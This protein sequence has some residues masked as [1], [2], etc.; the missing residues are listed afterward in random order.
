ME[1][2]QLQ[3]AMGWTSLIDDLDLGIRCFRKFYL[4]PTELKKTSAHF[5]TNDEIHDV[6][7]IDGA[8]C[9]TARLRKCKHRMPRAHRGCRGQVASREVHLLR[10]PHAS[11]S[12]FGGGAAK[13]TFF[14]EV[15][16]SPFALLR[17]S[18]AASS[19]PWS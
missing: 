5:T 7:L 3:R 1:S 14:W 15:E 8:A 12:G 9:V 18:S 4:Q 19:W 6:I 2:W 11:R 10:L 17:D 16:P 13:P